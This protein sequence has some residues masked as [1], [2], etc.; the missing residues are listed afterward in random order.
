MHTHAQREICGGQGVKPG[1][2]SLVS[3]AG[4]ILTAPPQPPSLQKHVP[5]GEIS[6]QCREPRAASIHLGG[7]PAPRSTC[8]GLLPLASELWHFHEMKW[9][10]KKERGGSNSPPAQ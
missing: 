7:S 2:M 4:D 10:K 5:R 3:K 9:P 8:R 1:T 6:R